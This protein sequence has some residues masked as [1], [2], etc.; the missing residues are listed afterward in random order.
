VTTQSLDPGYDRTTA[1]LLI[2]VQ[3]DFADP[4]GALAVAGGD[5]IIPFLNRQV[6]AA[7]RSGAL[8][9]YTQDWH[10]AS[11]PHFAR[12]GGIWPVHCVMD[13]WGA[14]LHPNLLVDGPRVRKGSAGEDGYSGFSTRDPGTGRESPT[15][16]DGLLRGAG[17]ERVVIAGLATDYCVKATALDAIRLGYPTRILADGIRPVDLAPGDGVRALAEMEAAGV[18]VVGQP[19]ASQ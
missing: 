5:A 15:E 9:A 18:E 19:V 2:D 8:V 3:N 11:T 7:R 17:I 16:L 6:G 12:D 10:P 14:E 1:L 4:G 13:T